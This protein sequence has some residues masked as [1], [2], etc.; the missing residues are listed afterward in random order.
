MQKFLQTNMADINECEDGNNGGCTHECT[1]TRG[2]YQCSC[3][4]GYEFQREEEE[5]GSGSGSGSGRV[6]EDTVD[7]RMTVDPLTDAGRLCQGADL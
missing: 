5:E 1:N 6:R 7:T 2:S 4:L 3:R